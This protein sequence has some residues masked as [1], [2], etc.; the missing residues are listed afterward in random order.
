MR[1]ETKIS[2]SRLDRDRDG[3]LVFFVGVVL[4]RVAAAVYL[5]A[6]LLVA[7]A[8]V[9]MLASFV[10][11]SCVANT[12][13]KMRR[14]DEVRNFAPD[15]IAACQRVLGAEH[16]NTLFLRTIYA[17]ALF[18][19]DDPEQAETILVDVTRIARRVLGPSH[20]RTTTAEHELRF[21]RAPGE[22][23]SGYG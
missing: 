2:S 17:R 15:R 20:P 22:V 5:L 10:T 18:F 3:L 11:I 12:L 9:V 16:E 6:D 19:E 4:L 1:P 14:F 13:S 21:V 23:R 7:A 8:P